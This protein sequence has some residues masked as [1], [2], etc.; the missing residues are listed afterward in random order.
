MSDACGNL[1][2]ARAGD[3]AQVLAIYAPIVRDTIISFEVEPPSEA[4]MRE[5]I[6]GTLQMYPWLVAEDG[7]RI[8]GYAYASAH[9]DRKA[10]QWSVDVSCYVHSASR[11]KG[12]GKRLYRALFTILRRQGFQAAFAGIALPNA[13]SEA[14]HASVG[15][16]RIGIYR[17]VG[18]KAGAWRDTVWYQC[19]LGAALPEPADPA[20]LGALGPGILDHL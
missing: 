9:R 15:F 2:L 7:D 12:I 14:L 5:R 16:E 6:E 13:A 20:P 4:A 10:Y 8:L 11:G 1:R 19:A 3:A 17:Q 18:Y